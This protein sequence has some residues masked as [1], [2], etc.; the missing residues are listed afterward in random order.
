MKKEHGAGKPEAQVECQSSLLISK[1]RSILENEMAFFANID[2]TDEYINVLTTSNV[3][4]LTDGYGPLA[5]D[6]LKIYDQMKAPK[7]AGAEDRLLRDYLAKQYNQGNLVSDGELAKLKA[8]IRKGK[9]SQQL[10]LYETKLDEEGLRQKREK[11]NRTDSS[12]MVGMLTLFGNREEDDMVSI[13]R[14]VLSNWLVIGKNLKGIYGEIDFKNAL[15]T[16]LLLKAP[17]LATIVSKEPLDEEKKHRHQAYIS[18]IVSF[19]KTFDPQERYEAFGEI[20]KKCEV[21][22]AKEGTQLELS[23][24]DKEYLQNLYTFSKSLNSGEEVNM[25]NLYEILRKTILRRGALFKASEGQRGLEVRPIDPPKDTFDDI[26]GYKDQK[27]FYGLL[28]DKVKTHDP[29]LNDVKMI[30]VIGEPGLGKSLGVRVF[31]ANLPED[32]IGV[33]CESRVGMNSLS[34]FSKIAKFHPDMQIFLSI[35]DIDRLAGDRETSPFTG[36]FL[37]IDST[38]PDSLPQNLHIIATTNRP[39]TIDSAVKRPGRTSVTLKYEMPND[40]DRKEIVQIHAERNDVNLSEEVLK[41]IVEKTNKLS[42]DEIRDVIWKL[43][44]YSIN[45]PTADII[46]DLINQIRTQNKGEKP[47][48]F[49]VGNNRGKTIFRQSDSKLNFPFFK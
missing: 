33:V 35:E 18:E 19:A 4:A 7:D 48:G 47:T 24:F 3:S 49:D 27:R 41:T 11:R 37:E 9:Y 34:L 21:E 44:F 39:E 2:S 23:S 25:E 20:T 29:I 36:K 13:K 30:L 46:D 6:I 31:L 8:D 22:W 1:E 38:D 40:E 16:E 15:V 26:G 45:N 17:F 10:K 28:S 12:R 42:P 14:K 5:G 43:K 32:A